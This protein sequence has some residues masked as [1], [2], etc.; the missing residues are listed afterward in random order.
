MKLEESYERTAFTSTEGNIRKKRGHLLLKY[1]KPLF[2][3]FLGAMP[4]CVHTCIE[5]FSETKGH[6][7]ECDPAFEV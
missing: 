3:K 4:L 1:R 7:P 5:G 2:Q 6:L